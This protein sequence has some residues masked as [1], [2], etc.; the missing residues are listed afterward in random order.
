[1][2]LAVEMDVSGLTDITVTCSVASFVAMFVRQIY[3]ATRSVCVQVM[4][5]TVYDRGRPPLS[6]SALV[7]VTVIDVNDN[8][9]QF[10]ESSYVTSVTEDAV[11][12]VPHQLVR[13]VDDGGRCVCRTTSS[14]R[15]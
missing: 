15:T 2:I 14:C 10:I 9:P 6:S 7:N 11:C 1:M 13:G 5:L 3:A 12:V 4:T 8:E